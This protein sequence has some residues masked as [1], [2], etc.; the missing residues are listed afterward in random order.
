MITGM[1]HQIRRHRVELIHKAT[2]VLD[3]SLELTS[4]SIAIKSSSQLPVVYQVLETLSS[5][6][7]ESDGNDSII[8]CLTRIDE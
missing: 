5:S 2:S 1:K 6:G 8:I 7:S 3:T 4:T